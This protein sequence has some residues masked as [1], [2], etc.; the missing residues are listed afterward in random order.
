MLHMKQL[1]SPLNVERDLI[2]FFF[3]RGE[4]VFVVHSKG[5]VKML[6]PLTE[7]LYDNS[8]SLLRA[9]LS[10][11]QITFFWIELFSITYY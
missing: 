6:L 5:D 11:T 7:R 1:R 4:F 3:N 10:R 8:T 2:A 9:Q